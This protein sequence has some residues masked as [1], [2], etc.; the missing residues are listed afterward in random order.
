MDLLAPSTYW[1]QTRSGQMFDCASPN[2]LIVDIED[3]AAG[4][5]KLCRFNG[6]CREFYSVAE[7]SLRVSYLVEGEGVE[8]ELYALLHDAHEAYVGDVP[9]PLKRFLGSV[10][11]DLEEAVA[12]RVRSE[13]VKGVEVEHGYEHYAETIREADIVMLAFEKEVLMGEPSLDWGIPLGAGSRMMVRRMLDDAEG[14]V[15]FLD[16]K[17]AHDRFLQRYEELT[18]QL[19]EF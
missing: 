12:A 7:H 18:A 19:I 4:L 15:E 6:Q 5:S 9:T 8:C 2:E 13:L 1:L 11:T 14:G 17:L 16:H 3:V 10:Y